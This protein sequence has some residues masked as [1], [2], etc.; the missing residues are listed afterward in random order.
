MKTGIIFFILLLTFPAL[1]KDGTYKIEPK[2]KFKDK[3]IILNAK[4]DFPEGTKIKISIVREVRPTG[5]KELRVPS[6][7][8]FHSDDK[9]DKG[10]YAIVKSG[11]IAGT[12]K[13]WSPATSSGMKFSMDGN[14]WIN[15][16]EVLVSF[17]VSQVFNKKS[18]VKWNKPGKYGISSFHFERRVKFKMFWD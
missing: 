15:E 4:T 7:G 17:T 11:M 10:G 1:S 8:Y 6:V 14:E 13:M 9:E 12:F 2:F 16:K 18:K 5:E 3:T